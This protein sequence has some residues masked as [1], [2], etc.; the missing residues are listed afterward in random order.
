VKSAFDKIMDTAVSMRDPADGAEGPELAIATL[1]QAL[2]TPQARDWLE[3]AD[4]KGD[5]DPFLHVL[6]VWLVAHRSDS[7]SMLLIV[8]VPRNRTLPAGTILHRVDEAVKVALAPPPDL[9]R[10]RSDGEADADEEIDLELEA[11]DE[12]LETDA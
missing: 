9:T 5:L 10:R 3:Q 7:E 1:T 8:P 11:S 6:A 2:S 4:D 12:L